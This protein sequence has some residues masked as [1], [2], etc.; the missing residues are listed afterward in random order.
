MFI[1]GS[2]LH[3]SILTS[4]LPTLVR[5]LKTSFIS[6]LTYLTEHFTSF[7]FCLWKAQ[8]IYVTL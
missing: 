7:D 4:I 5:R 8:K 2:V 3:P 1:L 6:P